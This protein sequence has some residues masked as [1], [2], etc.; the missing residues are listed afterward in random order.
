M[1]T[2]AEMIVTLWFVP[3]LLCIVTPL[4]VLAIWSVKR[5]IDNISKAVLRQRRKLTETGYH[6]RATA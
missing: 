3:V 5:L 2:T 4:S 6:S 1:F